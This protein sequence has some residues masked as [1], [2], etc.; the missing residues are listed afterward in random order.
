MLQQN[1]MGEKAFRTSIIRSISYDQDEIIQW[2]LRMHCNNAD[3]FE[4]DPCF[5]N[6]NFY[7]NI[8]A[9]EMSFDITPKFDTVEQADSTDLS[10]W[11]KVK[12]GEFLFNKGKHKD[13][14]VK[15]HKGYLEWLVGNP[16]IENNSR[17]VGKLIGQKLKILT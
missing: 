14:P 3:T 11:F 7:N 4:C 10:N 5:G 1:L 17:L 6:G 13:Y 12:D 16:N 9:P 15:E 8:P 2:I